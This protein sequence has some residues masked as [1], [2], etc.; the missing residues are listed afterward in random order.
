MTETR[1]QEHA[2]QRRLDAEI[3]GRTGRW[4]AGVAVLIAAVTLGVGAWWVWGLDQGMGM[5]GMV[6][7]DVRL[8]PVQGLYEGEEVYFVHP[9]ASDEEVAGVLTEMMGDSPVLVVPALADV[10]AEA[11]DDVYVFANG[12]EGSGPLGY[13]PDV[14]VSAPG[15]P[16]Y[17]PLRQVLLVTWADEGDARQLGSADEVRAA[18][19]AGELETEAS[20][21]VVNMPFLTWPDG[22][23]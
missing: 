4:W 21:V 18:E 13:Q 5:N 16:D 14:F 6:P 8:P 10:P 20:G 23:R 11:V 7:T 17:S 3:D 22:R 9:E 19:Q 2:R 12:V 1:S 15:D